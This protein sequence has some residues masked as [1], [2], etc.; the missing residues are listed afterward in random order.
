MEVP[1]FYAQFGVMANPDSGSRLPFIQIFNEGEKIYL[2]DTNTIYLPAGY[3][4]LI[5][6]IFLAT[7]EANSYMEIVPEL[8]GTFRA[9]YSFFA[10]TGQERNTSASGS[11]TT[12]EAATQPLRLRFNLTY[13]SVVRNIDISGAVSVTPLQKLKEM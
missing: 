3:L 11:F 7:P 10:P 6:F 2:E 8:N 12:N 13:P 9:L 4:Y 1:D 5:D